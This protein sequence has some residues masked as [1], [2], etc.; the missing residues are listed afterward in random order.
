M[1][2][3]ASFVFIAIC[4]VSSAAFAAGDYVWEEKFNA[5]LPKAEQGDA[6]AQFVIGEMYEKG[7]GAPRD[8]GVAFE[9]FLK[10]AKQGD[11]KSF[12]KVGYCYLKARGVEKDF[13]KAREW[14]KKASDKGYVRAYYYLG[15]IFENGYGVLQD[16]D[17]AMKWYKRALE[18]G[19]GAAAD[20]MNAV[21]R[22]RKDQEEE[23]L[24]EEKARAARVKT[25]VAVAS[26]P[27]ST[28]ASS[29]PAAADKSTAPT[30]D[31]VLSGGWKER[32]K[33][34]EFLPSTIT[35]CTDKG[36]S[37][38]C[39]SKELQRNI[40]MA[41]I[42]YTTKAII[43]GFKPEGSFKVSYRNEVTKITVTDPEFAD[44]GEKV[45]VQLGWQ[46]A[47]HQLTCQFENDLSVAC[48]KNKTRSIKLHRDE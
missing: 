42:D 25:R 22:A 39:L 38:E 8:L 32:N 7:R 12:Y 13:D 34:A 15:E 26:E 1:N 5:E 20:R 30:K 2:K 19:Y 35:K 3:L 40:G 9:W 33:G 37:I 47:E 18:G 11:V 36:P 44:S 31:R 46:D 43:F 45:P 27:K 4:A 6:K 24:A 28:A 14:F 48:T 10:A 16:Y 29:Q 23:R 21:N 17:E 41:D